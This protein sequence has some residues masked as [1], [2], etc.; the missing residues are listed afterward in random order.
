MAMKT[1]VKFINPDTGEAE[2]PF[3]ESGRT[4]DVARFAI[5]SKHRE[6]YAGGLDSSTPHEEMAARL[7]IW[8]IPYN[9]DG[10]RAN[11]PIVTNM[12]LNLPDEID[13][14]QAIWTVIDAELTQEYIGFVIE[15]ETRP[16]QAP[17]MSGNPAAFTSDSTKYGK[18][19]KIGWT[20]DSITTGDYYADDETMQANYFTG[21]QQASIIF[22]TSRNI[23]EGTNN[24]GDTPS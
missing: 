22:K 17:A 1:R 13:K 6:L 2:F 18:G 12:P 9:H 21:I 11:Q 10:L 8:G 5:L 16:M 3:V 4:I 20:T 19:A 23:V 24:T 7:W 14:G 15:V